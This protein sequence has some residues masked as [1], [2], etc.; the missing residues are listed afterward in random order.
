MRIGIDIRPIGKK[1][2]GD[3]VVFFN[4]VKN[5]AKIDSENEYELFTDIVDENVLKEINEKLEIV[6]NDNFK[7]I[8][9]ETP[10]RYSW[11]FWSLG[12][13]LR[14][15][16]VDIYHTQY[17]TPWFVPKKIKVVTIIH[18]ISF[19]FFSQFIKWSDLF[20]LKTL[21]PI[22]LRRAD[23][24][25]AVSEFTKNEIISYYKTDPD[26]IHVAYNSIADEFSIRPSDDEKGAARKKYGLPEKYILYIG[27]LQPRK[28][29]PSLI[30]AFARIQSKIPDLGL[31]IGGN[32][33]AHNFDKRID[34]KI[35]ELGLGDKVVFPGYIDDEDKAAV[36]AAAH[37]FAFPSLYEGFGIPIL[38]AMS[39]GV[40]VVAS[41]IKPLREVGGE[42]ALYVDT[43]SLDEFSNML[44]TACADDRTR[45]ELSKGAERQIA[46][47]SWK[48]TAYET[49]A[50]Y[51]KL[52][53]N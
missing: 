35:Q 17:I 31:V 28:N 53:H 37:V 48:N 9:L 51:Q 45:S 41:N 19:N 1:R 13:Y 16:P 39:Q 27:T 20:F 49:L 23:A 44:Y 43:E 8:T 42:G 7:I 32:K 36:F 3:E 12:A 11:N 47:F 21:I 22:S 18:D 30:E 52:L 14:K 5:L 26:K 15:H 6:D 24:I 29:I 2:T 40:S 25:I 38:E 4:L 34:G 33:N 46:M 10:N 50:L